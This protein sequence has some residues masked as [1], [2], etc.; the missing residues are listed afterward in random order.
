[1]QHILFKIQLLIWPVLL[2]HKR[3]TKQQ[4]LQQNHKSLLGGIEFEEKVQ[5]RQPQPIFKEI[6]LVQLQHL[7]TSIQAQMAQ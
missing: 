6:Q 4:Q 1:M 7:T 3:L 2:L 5:F